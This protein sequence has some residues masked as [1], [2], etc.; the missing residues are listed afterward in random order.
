[1]PGG[2]EFLASTV[3]KPN[4]PNNVIRHLRKFFVAADFSLTPPRFLSGNCRAPAI[5][6]LLTIDISLNEGRV[7]LGGGRLTSHE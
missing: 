2:A 4:L 5:K 3:S 1:M 6:G 7:R